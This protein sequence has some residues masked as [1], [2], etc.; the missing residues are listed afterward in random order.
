VANHPVVEAG[1]AGLAGPVGADGRAVALPVWAARSLANIACSTSS[2]AVRASP[3]PAVP[4]LNA[5]HEGAIGQ[6]ED[7]VPDRAAQAP[8][9][10]GGVVPG[11]IAQQ[12]DECP[13]IGTGNQGAGRERGRQQSGHVPQHQVAGCPAVTAA[14]RRLAVD[15]GDEYRQRV[16]VLPALGEPGLKRSR[17]VPPDGGR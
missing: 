1:W 10:D 17:R 11:Q 13:G 14:E 6:P 9:Q 2:R 3:E 15:M 4:T 8:G 16:V 7:L 12:S 5:P